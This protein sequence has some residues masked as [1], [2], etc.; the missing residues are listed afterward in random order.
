MSAPIPTLHHGGRSVR[1]HPGPSTRHGVIVR[2]RTVLLLHC[3][4]LILHNDVLCPECRWLCP[5]SETV[6]LVG[7]VPAHGLSIVVFAVK[8]TSQLPHTGLGLEASPH[9]LHPGGHLLLL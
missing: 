4:P 9:A 7:V 3:F 2:D 5:D 8:C 1:R 6:L